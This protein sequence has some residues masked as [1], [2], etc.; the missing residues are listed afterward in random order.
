MGAEAGVLMSTPS[1]QDSPPCP[2]CPR[3]RLRTS[4]HSAAG[5][6]G[7]EREPVFLPHKVVTYKWGLSVQLKQNVDV[8]CK[9]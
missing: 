6:G 9:L 8:L 1:A 4:V 2:K 7:Q 5:G 3:P